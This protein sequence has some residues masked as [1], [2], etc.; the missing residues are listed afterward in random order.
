MRIAFLCKRRYT[1]GKDVILDH[2][3]RLY[4]IPYQLARRGHEVHCYCLDYHTPG[5]GAWTHE[6]APGSLAWESQSLGALK[7][8]RLPAYPRYLLR[9]L[10]AFQPHLLLGASDIPHVALCRWLAGRLGVP[11][12]VDLYD[13]FESFGQA[14]IPGF[15]A[16]LRSATRQA[17]VV[18]T[19]S[20][21]L[22]QLA[23]RSY[24]A[25]GKVIAMPNSTDL[26]VFYPGARQAARQRLGLPLQ[27]RLM[28]TA[29]VLSRSK[30]VEPIYQAWPR[31]A[32]E[33]PDLHLVLAGPFRSELPPPQGERV[34]YLGQLAHAQVADVFRALDVGI[35]S[36][37]DTP[38]G[39]YCFPQ[40]AYEMLA[41]GL[42]VVVTDIGE[43][44]TLFADTP[45]IRFAPNDAAGLAAAVNA[46]LRDPVEPSIRIRDW[47]ALLDQVAPELERLVSDT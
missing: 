9:R 40:K 1:G 3:G 2:Y 29:G 38:F 41:C 11:Y 24:G 32:A 12:A 35:I 13:N 26:Q 33:H 23:M 14:R 43:M 8:P 22:R 30:G 6:A 25:Q 27:V 39:R 19:A 20:E 45:Q 47:K 7:L 44:Q 18:I 37:L 5:A 21:P 36:I 10:R 28:G 17:T 4:E 16:A 15:V 31:L 42:H 46:Q 34:H